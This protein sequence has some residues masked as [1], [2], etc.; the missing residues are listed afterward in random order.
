MFSALDEVISALSSKKE[1]SIIVKTKEHSV[2]I[3]LDEIMYAEHCKR[4]IVYHL[5]N[6][7][8]IESVLLRTAF[9][10]NVQ[11]LLRD[12]RFV[13]C[14][15]SMVANLHHITMVDKETVIF[16]DQYKYYLSKKVCAEVRSAWYDFWF[17]EDNQ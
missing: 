9:M 10:E 16:K 5:T 13:A 7:K 3:P 11:E 17:G 15:I 2:K 6:G 1:K 4:A 8:T 12:N 14:G